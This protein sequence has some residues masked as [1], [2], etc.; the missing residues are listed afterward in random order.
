MYE[1]HWGLTARP[2]DSAAESRFYYPADPQQAA[3]L[4]LRYVVENRLGG[5]VLAG[6]SGLGKTL[7]AQQLSKQLPEHYAPRL[8]LVYPDL[9]VDA[10]LSYIAGELT[11][12]AEEPSTRDISLRCI[13]QALALNAQAGKH[14]LL[15]VDEA[16]LLRDSAALQTLRLLLNIEYES[17][18]TLTLLLVAQPSLLTALDRFPELNDR[19]AAR[20]V[21]RRFTLE[22]TSSYLQHRLLAAGSTRTIFDDSACEAI[23]EGSLGIPRRINRLAD[24]ALLVGYA[25]DYPKLNRTHIEAIAEELTAVVP[26]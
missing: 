8:H 11:S 23:Y 10:L 20:C 4:K 24:M 3:L 5:A 6:A 14:A 21:L 15:V 2:F 22:E 17:R 7:V 18:P 16:H 9:P 13:E 25:E 19:L 12:S 26:E 1:T